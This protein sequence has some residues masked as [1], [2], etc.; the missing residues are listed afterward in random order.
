MAILGRYSLGKL[1]FFGGLVTLWG[2]LWGYLMG[3]FMFS[4]T[5]ARGATP[6]G[7]PA[8]RDSGWLTAGVGGQ[9]PPVGQASASARAAVVIRL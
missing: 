4:P 7:L 8:S 1:N 2:Y 3:G 9:R 5:P 6:E